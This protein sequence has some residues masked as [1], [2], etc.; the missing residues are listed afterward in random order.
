[1]EGCENAGMTC[2]HCGNTDC[3]WY[4]NWLDESEEEE[5]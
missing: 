5:E 2:G 1:M 4:D 3:E